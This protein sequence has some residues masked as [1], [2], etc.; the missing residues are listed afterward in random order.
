MEQRQD[1]TETEV[2]TLA[3]TVARVEQN[4]IHASELNKLRFDS[5]DLGIKS[6]AGQLDTFTKRVEGILTGEIETPTG[7]QGRE[8]VADYKEWRQEVDDDRE[9][10]AILNG[11]VRLIGRLAVLLVSSNLLAIGAAIYA[12]A[13]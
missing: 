2:R 7:R 4:Q 9:A 13:N 11:Q 12:I 5:L 3:A 10:Q 8:I 6:L 1:S